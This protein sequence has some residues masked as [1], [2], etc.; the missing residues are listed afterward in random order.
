MPTRYGWHRTLRLDPGFSANSVGLSRPFLLAEQGAG[1][2]APLPLRF[3]LFGFQID[4]D[5]ERTDFFDQHVEGLG[6][7]R[8]HTVITVHDVFVHLGTAVHVIRLNG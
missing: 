1:S 7:A 2:T 8:L 6:H 3:V 5:T 4:I